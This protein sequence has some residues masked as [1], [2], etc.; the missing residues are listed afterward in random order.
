MSPWIEA[1]RARA[2]KAWNLEDEI[3]LIAAGRP[4]GKPGGLD[5]TYPY[6]PH[7]DYRWLT[8]A[9]RE[10]GILAFDPKEGWTHFE[11]VVDEIERV[12]GLGPEPTGQ[13]LDEL[14]PWLKERETRPIRRLGADEEDDGREL[15]EALWHARRAKDAGEIETFER[16]VAATA[17]AHEAARAA[18][19]VGVSERAVKIELEAA[20]FRAG[21]DAMGYATI[22][23]SG[24]NSAVFHFEPGSR[25]VKEGEFVLVDAGAEIGG[26]TADVTRTYHAGSVGNN[27]SWMLDV[28]R[29]ALRA[30]TGACRL[31]TEWGDVHLVAAHRIAASLN[32]AGVFRCSPESAVESEA[33]ALFFPHGIGHMV[34]LG[35]RDAS[36]A[37]PG[38]SDDRRFGGVRVR[39]DLPLGENFLVTVEPGLYFIPA[40]LKDHARRERFKNEI[41]WAAVEPFLGLGGVRLEDDVLVTTEGPRNLTESIPL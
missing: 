36:G 34:G 25:T 15:R 5:Q 35:V 3:V 13:P 12:W 40:L 18:V 6:I 24:P 16:A 19:Q 4:L 21:A 33:I 20:A 30:A 27:R 37:A 38:R 7:P 17:A 23:G 39:M 9:R 1:R 28:V 31:G 29:H 32:E 14:L 11:P 2:A 10:G 41:N 26:I 22:V 8:G